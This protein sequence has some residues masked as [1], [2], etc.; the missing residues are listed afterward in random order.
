MKIYKNKDETVEETVFATSLTDYT[1]SADETILG[2]RRA[3]NNPAVDF[4]SFFTGFVYRVKLLAYESN[5]RAFDFLFVYAC[6]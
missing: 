2:A 5:I 3:F 1:I 4:I 6:A